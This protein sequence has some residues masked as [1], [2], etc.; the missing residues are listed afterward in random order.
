MTRTI[1]E[2]D[3]VTVLWNNG[4]MLEDVIVK[5]VPCDVGDCWHFEKADGTI[6]V[7]NPCSSNFD[8]IIKKREDNP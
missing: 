6:L 5:H 4:E 2:G 1:F 7:Q 3:H 8:T